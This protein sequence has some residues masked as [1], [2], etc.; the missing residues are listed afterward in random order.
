MLLMATRT[1]TACKAATA[2]YT[3]A[4]TAFLLL[5]SEAMLMALY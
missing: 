4:Q 5:F 1:I 2:L 3:A